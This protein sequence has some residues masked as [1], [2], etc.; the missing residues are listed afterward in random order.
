MENKQ[1]MAKAPLW[2]SNF[3]MIC[4]ANL[5]IFLG[6][7]ML[8]P[9]LPLYV[10][11]LGGSESIVGLVIGVF[12]VSAVIIR[13][14]AGWALDTYG[15]K[16][17]FLMGLVVMAAITLAY[18]WVGVI[19][20]LLAL[21]LIH[22]IGWGV[23]STAA[24]TIAA[25]VVP[26]SRL[27]EGMGYFGLASTL[28]MAVAPALGLYIVTHYNFTAMFMLAAGLTVLALIISL[29]LSTADIK[30]PQSGAKARGLE[31]LFEPLAYR[32]SLVIFFVTTTY[33]A[34]VS[35]IALHAIQQ[36]IVNVGIFFTV[37][38]IVLSITRPV[39][40]MVL[41]RKGYDIVVLPG[42]LLVALGVII[43]GLAHNLTTFLLAAV[44]YG[45][46][47]GAVH[48]SMQAMTVR[49]VSPHRRGAANG[50]FF[51]A[52][53]L[54]IGIGSV[55]WG[56]VAQAIGYSSMYLLASIPVGFAL[57]AYLFVGRKKAATGRQ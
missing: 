36:G 14:V 34:M 53:D 52:F 16:A 38:A 1:I 39:L 12:T 43:L 13:P 3:I 33:G 37:Y 57:L 11:E 50:T 2:T 6:F 44:V 49:N 47:F 10:V 55:T 40:G 7:Q 42:L 31:S 32:P 48:P 26:K 17:I 56:A 21:R 23:G 28:S 25:D 19:L 8:M 41:D 30:Q 51:S 54:G 27:G 35:F 45:A 9:T 22:G 29:N 46:G 5:A 18:N 24:G 15:R 20:A 4:L